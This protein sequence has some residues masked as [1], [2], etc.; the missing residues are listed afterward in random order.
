MIW[1]EYE[2]DWWKVSKAFNKLNDEKLEWIA[3]QTPD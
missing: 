1:D 3:I 2:K